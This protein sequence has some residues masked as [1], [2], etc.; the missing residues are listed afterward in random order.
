MTRATQL[1]GNVRQENTYKR[2]MSTEVTDL[3]VLAESVEAEMM[4]QYMAQASDEAKRGFGIETT[5]IGSGVV[6]SARLDPYEFWSKALGFTE[7]VSRDVIDRVIEFYRERSTPTA[8]I[9]LAPW[10][11]LPL[12][13]DDICAAHGLQAERTVLKLAAPVSELTVRSVTD[14]RLS[15][16][17]ERHA[18]TW[19]EV[20]AEVFDM[21]HPALTAVLAQSTQH[22]ASIPF[23]AWDGDQI[24][25]AA[26]LYLHG[27]VG[28]LNTGATLPSHRGRGAQSALIAAR[29][30]AARALG[31]TWVVAETGLPAEGQVNP[32]LRNLER[33]GLRVLYARQSWRWR[34]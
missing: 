27:T 20:V 28:L 14:L 23:A 7:P 1:R 24:V 4:Y 22:P 6:V 21:E 12:D 11:P 5:R 17:D 8:L 19:A 13:W 25:A 2:G 32:S 18:Q 33:A 30:E 29:I 15:R 10:V 16:V 31:V 26:N 3:Q 9:H 34:A